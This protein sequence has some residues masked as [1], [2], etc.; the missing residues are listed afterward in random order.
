MGD[1]TVVAIFAIIGILF[2]TVTL[3]LSWFLRPFHNP[4]GVKACTYECGEIPEGQGWSQLRVGYYIYLL[5]FVIFD[6]EILFI[7]PWA[8]VL[9]DMKAVGLGLVAILDMLIFV[10]ILAVGLAYAWKKGVLKW[11]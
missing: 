11:E 2:V 1:Y 5:I 8:L 10:G 9:R 4:V 3:W 7:F 6:V